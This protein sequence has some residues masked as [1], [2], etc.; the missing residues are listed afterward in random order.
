MSRSHPHHFGGEVGHFV[1]PGADKIEGLRRRPLEAWSDPVVCSAG[2]LVALL[3]LPS[4][5]VARR[6]LVRTLIFRASIGD[7]VIYGTTTDGPM[8]RQGGAP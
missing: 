6:S 8:Q 2:S 1:L 7:R 3:T 5:R 4:V